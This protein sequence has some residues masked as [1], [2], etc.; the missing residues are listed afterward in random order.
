MKRDRAERCMSE[1]MQAKKSDTQ[2]IA[3]AR[4]DPEAFG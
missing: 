4:S 1:G 2:L 3:D